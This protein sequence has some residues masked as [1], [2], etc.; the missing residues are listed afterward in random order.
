MKGKSVSNAIYN[1]ILKDY[2]FKPV[3]QIDVSSDVNSGS[4]GV[5]CSNNKASVISLSPRMYNNKYDQKK[6][7][8]SV[9]DGFHPKGTGDMIQSVLTHELGHAITVNSKNEK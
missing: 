8:E 4:L 5:C 2:K 9:N 6:W 7:D 3:A 1:D